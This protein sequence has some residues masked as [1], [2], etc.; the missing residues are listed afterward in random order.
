MLHKLVKFHHQIVFTS[1]V[2]Q[3]NVF[4]KWK[5]LN[6]YEKCFLFHL[7][8]PIC[9]QNIQFF[10]FPSSP[11]FLRI[12]WL[13]LFQKLHPLIYA[14]QFVHDIINYPTFIYHIESGKSGE[15][16]K[17]IQQFEYLEKKEL[18]RWIKILHFIVFEGLSLVKK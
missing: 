17:K 15:K 2:I 3:Q 7:K 8:I 18:F 16:E 11:L 6:D 4:T 13:E 14:S 12:P 9:Y 10:V 1:Q 5:P